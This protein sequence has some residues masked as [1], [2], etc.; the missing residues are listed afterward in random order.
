MISHCTPIR[1]VDIHSKMLQS[2]YKHVIIT[3]IPVFR[4]TCASEMAYYLYNRLLITQLIVRIDTNTSYCLPTWNVFIAE[5]DSINHFA[6][7]G[8]ASS[9]CSDR[10]SFAFN[11]KQE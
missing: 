2:Q 8:N 10:L 9:G 7:N 5:F 4:W 6:C 11:I 1:A 3:S